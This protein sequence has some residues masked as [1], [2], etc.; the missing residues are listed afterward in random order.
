MRREVCYISVISTKTI[1]CPTSPLVKLPWHSYVLTI[2]H[3]YTCIMRCIDSRGRRSLRE[4][5]QSRAKKS[6]SDQ[7]SHHKFWCIIP[8]ARIHA[9]TSPTTTMESKIHLWNI[10]TISLVFARWSFFYIVGCPPILSRPSYLALF[11]FLVLCTHRWPLLL[12][13]FAPRSPTFSSRSFLC[14]CALSFAQLFIIYLFLIFIWFPHCCVS[15]VSPRTGST[16]STGNEKHFA[17]FE[18]EIYCDTHTHTHR[19]RAVCCQIVCSWSVLCKSVSLGACATLWPC[20]P[21]LELW[22]WCYHPGCFGRTGAGLP[23]EIGFWR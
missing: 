15:I 10:E 5:E 12:D 8:S 16:M 3:L 2:Q 22:S 14:W 11:W 7:E 23:E 17:P 21:G 1:L 20:G 6:E 13:S 18:F 4:N 9:G 19:N